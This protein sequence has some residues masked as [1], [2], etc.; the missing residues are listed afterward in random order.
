MDKQ[1][2]QQHIQ[3]F[4]ELISDLGD[5]DTLNMVIKSEGQTILFTIKNNYR[6]LSTEL[7]KREIIKIES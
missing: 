1:R 2:L 5:E 3:N 7:I 4:A 6:I